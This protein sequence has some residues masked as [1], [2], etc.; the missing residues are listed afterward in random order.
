MGDVESTVSEEGA[1]LEYLK[2]SGKRDSVRKK[3]RLG[4]SEFVHGV[5]LGEGVHGLHHTP[6]IALS[7]E[8]SEETKK[9]SRG[10]ITVELMHFCAGWE[11]NRTPA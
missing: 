1:N 9:I 7:T 6:E 5:D 8:V 3:R 10:L 11:D 2:W 4:R